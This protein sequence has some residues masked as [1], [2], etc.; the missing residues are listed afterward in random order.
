MHHLSFG[1]LNV[2]VNV[3]IR[4]RLSGFSSVKL[5][6]MFALRRAKSVKNLLSKQ[7]RL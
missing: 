7:M 2:V 5:A 3:S 4:L 6:V 1:W